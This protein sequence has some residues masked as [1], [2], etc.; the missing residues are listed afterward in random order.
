MGFDEWLSHDNFFELNPTLSRNGGPP[1]K[2]EGESS[3]DCDRRNDSISGE[4]AATEAAIFCRRLVW[5]TA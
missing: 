5:F 2:F 1:E 4:G 3:R